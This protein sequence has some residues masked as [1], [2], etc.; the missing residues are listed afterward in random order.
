MCQVNNIAD[1]LS[2]IE[3][4]VS[5]LESERDTAENRA[6]AAEADAERLANEVTDSQRHV[7]ELE[8]ELTAMLQAELQA[9]QNK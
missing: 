6:D 9:L 8:A 2:A 1:A 7:L 3:N 4:M 5:D